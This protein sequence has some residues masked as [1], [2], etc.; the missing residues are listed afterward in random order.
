MA[1]QVNPLLTGNGTAL[2]RSTIDFPDPFL[3]MASLVMPRS[4]RD[5]LNLCEGI[6]LKNG[7]YKMAASRV[8]RYFVTQIEYEGVDEGKRSKLAQ[9]MDNRFH[10][11][12]ELMLNGDDFLAYGMSLSSIIL[13]FRRFLECSRCHTQRPLQ[14]VEWEFKNWQFMARCSR[15]S[16]DKKILHKHIDRRSTEED[17]IRNK[18]WAP[19]DIRMQWHPYSQDYEYYWRI[20]SYFSDQIK[21]GNPFY[22]EH[23]PWEIIEAIRYNQLFK[24]NPGVVYHMCEKTLAG[25]RTGGWG[26]S[27]LLSNF[28]HAWY[29]QILKRYNEALA[30]DYVVPFRVITPA[31]QSKT[32]DPLINMNL[33]GFT[34]NVLNMVREH[35]QDPATWHSLPFPINY[36]ALGGEANSLATPELLDQGMDELL[37]GIGIP[38]EMYRGTLSFQEMPAALR[39]FQQTWPHLV[40]NFNGYLEWASEI[41]CTAQ[42]WDKP[43]RIYMQPVT[44]ADD[45]ERRQMMLQMAAGNMVSRRT[46]FSPWGIDANEE[47]RRVMQEQKEFEKLQREYAEDMKSQQAANDYM[48]GPQQQQ[49]NM[50][51]PAGMP[52]GTQPMMG[53][54]VAPGAAGGAMTPQDMSAQAQEMAMQL[55]QM[56]YEARRPELINLKNSNPTMHA[57]VK[58]QLEEVR[59]AAASQ[60][61]Q[62]VLQGGM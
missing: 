60:G 31:A 1:T 48:A 39:L 56:P 55:A 3:D 21:K 40:G 11:S 33:Q 13:P 50:G 29:V 43:A 49:P 22:V 61:K 8:V 45:L 5:I 44:M 46:A 9:F 2:T 35:R 15:C 54:G 24:F 47:Q 10:A 59:G 7:T 28:S 57:L 12:Q 42:N 6:W 37:N 32:G 51:A 17:K 27:R 26:V 30:H 36:Q 52:P 25:V 23:T 41:I 18:R 20:P 4:I 58:Q 38:S 34:Q 62:M 53:G 19:Q 14:E 16:S